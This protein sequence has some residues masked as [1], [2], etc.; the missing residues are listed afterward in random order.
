MATLT[1]EASLRAALAITK[2][3]LKSFDVVAAANAN[4]TTVI[5]AAS[6]ETSAGSK[7]GNFVVGNDQI[8]ARERRHVAI[9]ALAQQRAADAANRQA[10][11]DR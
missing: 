8:M 2:P 1:D 11:K 6:Y 10:E 7:Q 5:V 3:G 9:D 4:A